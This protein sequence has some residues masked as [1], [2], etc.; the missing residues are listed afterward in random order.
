[1][2]NPS[3][4]VIYVSWICRSAFHHEGFL[5]VSG[6]NRQKETQCSLPA[7]FAAVLEVVKLNL[8]ENLIFYT[9]IN[10]Q[11]DWRDHSEVNS[12]YTSDLTIEIKIVH[13]LT[14]L[15]Y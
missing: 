6:F 9:D 3:D 4:G 13:S 1:M 14:H 7:Q 12:I 10:G 11:I 15:R 5:S 2:L 8:P